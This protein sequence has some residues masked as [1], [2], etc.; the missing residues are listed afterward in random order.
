MVKRFKSSVPS[1]FKEK[2]M[3]WKQFSCFFLCSCIFDKN[4]FFSVFSSFSIA[5]PLSMF[6]HDY[7]QKITIFMLW[8]SQAYI[9][10]ANW[11][12]IC[13]QSQ[14]LWLQQVQDW[15]DHCQRWFH[16][17]SDCYRNK[18]WRLH[19]LVWSSLSGLSHQLP[20]N[21]HFC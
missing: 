6:I 19:P 12:Y 11:H 16:C 9:S 2:L 8:K 20:S 17:S 7:W 18:C 3:D 10:L 4:I 1:S 13:L 21:T 5:P 15:S 14:R